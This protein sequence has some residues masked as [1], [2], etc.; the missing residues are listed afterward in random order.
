MQATS[1]DSEAGT[2]TGR[3]LL[4][5]LSVQL[6]LMGSSELADLRCILKLA[7]QSPFYPPAARDMALR[8]VGELDQVGPS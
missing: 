1:V 3:F 7:S 6:H 2:Q 8:L 4:P 5:V